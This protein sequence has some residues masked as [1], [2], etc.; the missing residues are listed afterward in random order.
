MNLFLQIAGDIRARGLTARL[1]AW[2]R[3]LGYRL[4]GG[5]SLDRVLWQREYDDVLAQARRVPTNAGIRPVGIVRDI[6]LKH[7]YYEAACL[8]LGI[9]YSLVDI[10]G[11]DW[12]SKLASAEFPVV[13]ARP[14]VLSPEGKAIYDVRLRAMVE[15]TGYNVFPDLTSLLL[16][17]SKHRTTEWLQAHGIPMPATRLFHDRES[18]MAFVEGAALPLVFKTDLGSETAGVRILWSR[19]D[20]GRLVDACFGGG[21][22]LPGRMRHVTQRGS[23]LLQE[24]V[25]DAREWRI[26]RIGDSFFGHRKGKKGEFHSGSKIIEFDTPPDRLFDFCRDITGKG[27]FRSMAIDILEPP[28][29]R[30]LVIEMHAYFGCNSPHVMAV[31]GVP[32]RF[33]HEQGR[34]RFEQGDFNR[35]NS[36]NLRVEYALAHARERSLTG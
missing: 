3:D 25:P 12:K 18:A 10:T 16:Y 30:Y 29:G 9:A 21:F 34:W 26:V 17:E 11:D 14:F 15:E 35:N 32:G 27:G 31:N 2:M 33:L 8:E 19:R 22:R 24:Y 4:V 36:C 23:M 7:S 5:Y 6:M 28:D 20:A 13:F 1:P